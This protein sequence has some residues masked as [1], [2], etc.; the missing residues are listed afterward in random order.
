V[1]CALA[2]LLATASKRRRIADNPLALILKLGRI[3][4]MDMIESMISFNEQ[5]CLRRNS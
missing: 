1:V 4:L 3:P 5:Q 2:R